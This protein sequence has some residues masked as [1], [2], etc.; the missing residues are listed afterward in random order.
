VVFR[1]VLIRFSGR[2]R[3]RSLGLGVVVW[4]VG[5]MGVVVLSVWMRV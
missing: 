5:S 3:V 4:V 2:R 1:L